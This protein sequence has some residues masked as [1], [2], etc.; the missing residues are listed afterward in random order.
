MPFTAAHPAIILP[1]TYLP[2]KWY[3]LTGLIM[4]S[5]T[6]D[7]EY[8]IRMKVVSSFSHT[9]EGIFWFNL[10]LGLLITFVF[11]NLVRES[12]LSNSPY[13][14][15]SRS[16]KLRSFEWNEYFLKNWHIVSI[17]ILIGAAS[18][19]FWDSFTHS[20]GFFVERISFLSRSIDFMSFQI[21]I[22][23]ILQHSSTLIGGL[24]I[25]YSF[26]KLPVSKLEM[27]QPSIIYWAT[28]L[29]IALSIFALRFLSG[30]DIKEYGNVIVTIISSGLLSLVITPIALRKL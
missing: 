26:L 28:L 24:I 17:S 22:F 16:S 18:H 12:L 14:I 30:L 7:F 6:P 21:P 15:N 13:F 27:D 3:S 1:L 5:I 2:G 23:K 11:H 9:I 20:Y 19:I 4:G 25:V 29:G 8:F 10:P